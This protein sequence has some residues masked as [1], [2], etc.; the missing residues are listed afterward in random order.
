MEH[1]KTIEKHVELQ[2]VI[3][4]ITCD[5]CKKKIVN[6]EHWRHTQ[7][8]ISCSMTIDGDFES[9]EFDICE[10][11]FN[12]ELVPWFKSKNAFPRVN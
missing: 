3:D 5:I 6:S 11:C 8:D 2:T 10:D 4:Y 1:K 9:I 12:G 7:C